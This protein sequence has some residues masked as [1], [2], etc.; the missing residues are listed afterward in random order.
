LDK[1]AAISLCVFLI[2]GQAQKGGAFDLSDA[3]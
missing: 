2:D 1:P 3:K